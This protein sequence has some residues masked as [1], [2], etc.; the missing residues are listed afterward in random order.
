MNNNTLTIILHP[1]GGYLNGIKMVE[2]VPKNRIKAVL[3]SGIIPDMYEAGSYNEFQAHTC[4]GWENPTKQIENYLKRYSNEKEGVIAE[5]KKP[6][7]NI[8]RVFPL[9]SL[10]LTTIKREIRNTL[11]DGLYKDFDIENA[12]FDILRIDCERAGITCNAVKAYCEHRGEWMADLIDRF[13]I[14]R[15]QAKRLMLSMTFSSEITLGWVNWLRRI[16]APLDSQK[17]IWVL[18][19]EAELPTIIDTIR[20]A[21][22]KMYETASAK[23]KGKSRENKLGTFFS[24]YL[25]EREYQLVAHCVKTLIETTQL[26]THPNPRVKEPTGIYEFDGTKIL[27]QNCEGMDVVSLLNNISASFGYPVRWADK[28]MEDIKDISVALEQ[29]E[30]D[31]TPDEELLKVLRGIG[32]MDTDV[33]I[34]QFIDHHLKGEFIYHLKEEIWYCWYENKWYEGDHYFRKALYTKVEPVITAMLAPYEERFEELD[35]DDPN[36]VKFFNIKGFVNDVLYRRLR[37]HKDQNEICGAGK[38]VFGKEVE[39][40]EKDFLLGFENGVFDFE[41]EVFRPYRFDDY[42]TWSCK[43]P[44]DKLAGHTVIEDGVKVVMPKTWNEEDAANLTE[45]A[46]VYRKIFPNADEMNLFFDII[47]T[48]LVGKAIEHLFIFNGSGRNG[49]GFNNEFLQTCYG[50]YFIYGDVLILSEEVKSDTAR[51]NPALAILDKKRYIV[52]KEPPAD[53]PINNEVAKD[54]TGGGEKTARMLY[55]NKTQVRLKGTNI[56]ECNTK[57]SMKNKPDEAECLRIID[58]PFRS[59]F[60]NGKDQPVDEENF[61]FLVNASLK[62]KSWQHKMR[63]YFMNLMIGHCLDMKHR[64]WVFE[65]PQSIIDRSFDYCMSSTPEHT[66][67]LEYFER[68]NPA[69]EYEKDEDITLM[70][71]WK[72][73]KNKI[74]GTYDKTEKKTLKKITKDKLDEFFKTN[75][76][77]KKDYYNNSS[78]HSWCLRDY[79]K[80]PSEDDDALDEE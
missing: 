14:G 30:D 50:D 79:R 37:N 10:G 27:L 20:K 54:L 22:P 75:K 9:K 58:I 36:S 13:Q 59:T 80:R 2:Y 73:F 66:I 11:I 34:C 44:M 15:K 32:S 21:N 3:K 33:G 7:S 23:N 25:Q 68:R 24:M 74:D 51:P 12:Q 60:V 17:P 1:T 16:K 64:N 4:N 5:Y 57:P 69:T 26:Y 8:G 41:E 76:L 65:K 77:Y 35:K 62:D 43:Y 56:I 19:L 31:L 18:E 55:S 48:G 71:V 6:K 61:R 38:N 78:K 42:M 40:N 70:T 67:F 47:S 28:E 45:L 52:M 39:F 46:E 49:K 72:A 29:V 53:K 63:P